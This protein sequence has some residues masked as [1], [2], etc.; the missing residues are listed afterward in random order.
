MLARV[1]AAPRRRAV[2]RRMLGCGVWL[3]SSMRLWRSVWL[4]SGVGRRGRIRVRGRGT[5]VRW[6]RLGGGGRPAELRGGEGI[7]GGARGVL[8]RIVRGARR[9][10]GAVERGLRRPRGA[11]GARREAG[12]RRL[13]RQLAADGFELVRINRAHAHTLA[14]AAPE[15]VLAGGDHRVLH[16]HVL[17]HVDVVHIDDGIAVDDDVVDDAGATPAPPPRPTNEAAA[18][19]PGYHRFA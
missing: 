11:S 16:V 8:W 19:P 13:N 7:G 14:Q 10:H 6:G 2:W 17:I 5:A 4:G 18:T 9:N 1:S 12:R 3:R 15:L